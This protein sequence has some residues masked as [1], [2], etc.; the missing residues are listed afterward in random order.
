ME[1]KRVQQALTLTENAETVQAHE[2]G[3][4]VQELA[5][6]VGRPAPTIYAVL[7]WKSEALAAFE[8]GGLKLRRERLRKPQ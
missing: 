1:K 6:K 7:K 2:E 8:S 5:K 3:L 4:R